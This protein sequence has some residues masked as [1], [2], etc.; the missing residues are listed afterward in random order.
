MQSSNAE[1]EMTERESTCIL[2]NAQKN[3][4]L[5][6]S[7]KQNNLILAHWS[8]HLMIY[9]RSVFLH[10]MLSNRPSV[11]GLGSARCLP[12][13]QLIRCR[14]RIDIDCPRQV[15]SFYDQKAFCPDRGKRLDD[16]K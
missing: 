14:D 15:D 3:E 7:T 4:Q 11:I 9:M 10:P 5:M 12:Q 6:I 1:T 8:R 13:C 2:T 16:G